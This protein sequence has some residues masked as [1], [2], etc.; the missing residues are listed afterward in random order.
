MFSNT[1]KEERI[2]IAF[3]GGEPLLEFELIK[4]ISQMI[5]SHPSFNADRVELSVVTNGTIF[6]DEIAREVAPLFYRI[7]SKVCVE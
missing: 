4:I 2:D 7:V 5:E 6:T 3:F 1:P